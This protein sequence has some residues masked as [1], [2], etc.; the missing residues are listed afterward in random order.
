MRR[1]VVLAGAAFIGLAS[2][3]PSAD[4]P[5]TKPEDASVTISVPG[6]DRVIASGILPT[7]ELDGVAITAGHWRHDVGP[8]GDAAVFVDTAGQTQFA[9]RCDS[10]RHRLLFVRAVP[11]AAGGM[12]KIITG[13]GA[14]SFVARPRAFAPGVMAAVPIDDSFISTAL[15]RAKG[16]IGVMLTGSSAP[17][18]TLAMPADGAIAAVIGDCAGRSQAQSS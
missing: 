10:A 15:A 5:P 8:A 4:T 13:S 11:A 3:A 16:R 6:P 14:A 17:G 18:A 7:P 2:C 9:L 1:T 12:L